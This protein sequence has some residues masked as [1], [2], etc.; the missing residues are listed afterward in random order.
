MTQQYGVTVPMQ[1]SKNG[2]SKPHTANTPTDQS[3]YA[4]FE[5]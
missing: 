1:A 5:P 2:E 3:S 4:V